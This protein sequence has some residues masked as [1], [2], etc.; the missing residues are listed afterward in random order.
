MYAINEFLANVS[1][2]F[3][4]ILP[5]CLVVLLIPG[6]MLLFGKG[7]AANWIVKRLKQPREN[8]KLKNIFRYY[9][10]YFILNAILLTFIIF[11]AIFY[12]EWLRFG[13]VSFF[14]FLH[15]FNFFYALNGERFLKK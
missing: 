13:A 3:L 5:L 10:I 8:Y 2:A 14:I 12:F 7:F 11:G 15:I 4:L 1:F 6:V 9:G